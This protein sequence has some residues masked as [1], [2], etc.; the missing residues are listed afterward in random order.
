[1]EMCG[2]IFRIR[3]LKNAGIKT[4]D[5]LAIRISF[6]DSVVYSGKILFA[7]TFG[8]V[9]EGQPLGYLNSLMNFSV[10]INMGNFADR[11]CIKNGPDWNVAI[12][13]KL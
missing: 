12:K 4:G 9:P 13:A 1:M 3:I 6:K 5:S 8:E 11:Y 2:P 10:A 7:N